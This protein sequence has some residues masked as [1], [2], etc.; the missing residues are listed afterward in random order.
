[1][2]GG[3]GYPG[4]PSIVLAHRTGTGPGSGVENLYTRSE[5]TGNTESSETIATI[6]GVLVVH[7]NM[8]VAVVGGGINGM[9][10]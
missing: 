3:A 2:T 6:G 8:K 7:G 10:L 9:V 4:F 5:A 1:M